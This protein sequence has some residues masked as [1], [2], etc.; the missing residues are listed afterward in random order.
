MNAIRE[1]AASDPDVAEMWA[2]IDAEFL[3]LLR[4]V[5]DALEAAGSLR[6]GLEAPRAADLLWML[7]H[8]DVWRLLASGGA[9]APATTRSGSSAPSAGSCWDAPRGN[10]DTCPKGDETPHR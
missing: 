8:P 5:A 3:G 1:G 2:R 9:G 6:P 7:N 4:P 10:P